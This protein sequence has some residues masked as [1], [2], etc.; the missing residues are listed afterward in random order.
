MVNYAVNYIV[1]KKQMRYLL[2]IS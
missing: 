1:N 2:S